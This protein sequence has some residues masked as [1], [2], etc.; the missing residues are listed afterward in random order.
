MPSIYVH[1]S[2]RDTDRAILEIYGIERD[3]NK[4]GFKGNGTVE[5]SCGE[6]NDPDANYCSNCG[7]KLDS[8]REVERKGTQKV[9]V[10]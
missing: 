4:N 9:L 6:S 5:C 2:G 3:S 8:S 10:K 1:L 7:R